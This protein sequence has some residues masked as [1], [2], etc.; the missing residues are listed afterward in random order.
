M[1]TA[2]PIRIAFAVLVPLCSGPTALAEDEARTC[3]A[4]E[5]AASGAVDEAIFSRAASRGVRAEWCERYDADGRSERIGAYRE[6]Y[7]GGGLRTEATYEA[8]RLAGPVVAYHE[9]GT[10]FLEGA[11]EG[12]E[13]VGPVT[14]RHTNGRLWWRGAFSEGALSGTVELKHPAGGLAA[15]MRFQGGR[16]DGEARTFYPLE[17]GG[18]VRSNVHVEADELVGVHRVFDPQG[19][20][21]RR[22]DLDAA[23]REWANTADA[24]APVAAPGTAP[25]IAETL[26]TD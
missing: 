4:G 1:K 8:G 7:P 22:I 19:R 17:F 16:E 23:P 11:L 21:V 20:V 18:G 24:G 6:H 13:W 14:L 2:A 25:G 15:E 3:R 10:V 5:T 12:G 26:A 9:D